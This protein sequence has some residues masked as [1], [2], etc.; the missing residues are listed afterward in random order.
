MCGC[1]TAPSTTTTN[2]HHLKAESR[3]SFKPLKPPIMPRQQW[4]QGRRTDR[5]V[6]YWPPSLRMHECTYATDAT[7]KINDRLRGRSHTTHT[8]TRLRWCISVD[9]Y[10]RFI[11]NG[12][13]VMLG[14]LG[15]NM[16]VVNMCWKLQHCNLVSLSCTHLSL[17]KS[18]T[19]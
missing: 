18:L 5:H 8:H 4:R 13:F 9:F 1:I 12:P 10:N 15:T 7:D 3:M 14:N 2:R 6:R 17:M 11:S 16:S 19:Q